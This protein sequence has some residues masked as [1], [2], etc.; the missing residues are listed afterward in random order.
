MNGHKTIGGV[1]IGTGS[2]GCVFKPS[3]ECKKQKSSSGDS[4]SKVFYGSESKEEVS[5]EVKMSGVIKQIKGS[6]AWAHVWT[7]SCIPKEY[8]KLVKDEPD[9]VACLKATPVTEDEFNIHRRMLIGPYA[10][11]NSL[12]VEMNIQFKSSVFSNKNAFVKGFLHIM[13]LMKPL[14]IGLKEMYKNKISHNDIKGDNIMID[15][16]GCKYIDY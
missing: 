3:L 15:A 16:D 12:F 11:K 10:G 9:I 5:I 1:L 4:V 13:R 2:F 8:K 7:K 6:E 14:F